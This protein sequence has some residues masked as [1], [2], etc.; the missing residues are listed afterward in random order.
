MAGGGVNVHQSG[1]VP[2]VT[3][4]KC[5]DVHVGAFSSGGGPASVGG[6]LIVSQLR[7]SPLRL[8]IVQCGAIRFRNGSHKVIRDANSRSFT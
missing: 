1:N 2:A 8:R 3:F 4:G 6:S 5:V 7:Q